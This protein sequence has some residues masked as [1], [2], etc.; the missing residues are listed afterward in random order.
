MGLLDLT[1]I[2]TEDYFQERVGQPD[3]LVEDELAHAAN[4]VNY[5]QVRSMD[6]GCRGC[7]P[8][9]DSFLFY[10]DGA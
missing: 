9:L 6:V 10:I 2:S 1:R 8:S 3:P 4:R 5:N 7:E